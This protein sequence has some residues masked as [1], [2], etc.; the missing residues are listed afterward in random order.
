MSAWIVMAAIT[1]ACADGEVSRAEV[2]KLVRATNTPSI[3]GG[4]IRFTPRGEVRGGTFFIAKITN[5][6]YAPARQ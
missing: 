5:S 3:L 2:V 4:T 6:K 1:K